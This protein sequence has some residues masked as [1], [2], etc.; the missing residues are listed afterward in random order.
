MPGTSTEP[1]LHGPKGKSLVALTIATAIAL[2]MLIGLG[3]W[4]WQRKVWKE[5]LIATMAAR[6]SADPLPRERWS[7]LICRPVHEVGLADS[8]EFT[9]VRLAGRF[10]HSGERHIFTTAPRGSNPGGPGYWVF[11]PF[12]VV[13]AARIYVNRGFVPEARKDPKSRPAGQLTGEVEIVGQIRTAEQRGMFTGT[14]S[15][16]ENVWFLRDPRE[17]LGAA[18]AN[19]ADGLGQWK[20]PGPSGLDFYIDQISPTPPGSLPTPRS[21]VIE[22]PNR[23]LEYALTWWG[24]A[25][26][27]VGVYAGFVLGRRRGRQ[28]YGT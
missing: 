25:L 17:L 13:G 26:T 18:A 11:T 21:G 4:Q 2:A 28:P 22:L 24:L 20:G 19:A 9:T 6:A 15:P 16:A 8:C 10:D 27:L 5:E 1:M 14:S 7:S 23:H 12:D 3:N